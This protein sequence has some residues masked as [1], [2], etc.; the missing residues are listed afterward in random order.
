M[1]P[2]FV[3]PRRRPR[4]AG[5]RVRLA[6]GRPRRSNREDDEPLTFGPT[7]EALVGGPLDAGLVITP[8]FEDRWEDLPVDD[9]IAT[10][11]ATRAVEP[12]S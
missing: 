1:R 12:S 2:V 9:R 5:D 10:F 7:L 3:A 11:M 4:R 8:M 6:R